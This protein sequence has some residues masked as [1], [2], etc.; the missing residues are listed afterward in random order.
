MATP[1]GSQVK[2]ILRMADKAKHNKRIVFDPL[3]L[4]L[5]GALEGELETVVENSSKVTEQ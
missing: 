1:D 4:F 5:D 3:V 2:G